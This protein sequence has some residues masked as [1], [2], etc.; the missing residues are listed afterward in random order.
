MERLP[1]RQWKGAG[2]G[3]ERRGLAS[4]WLEKMARTVRETGVAQK[5]RTADFTSGWIFLWNFVNIFS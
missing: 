4:G 3:R 2:L 5:V 1:A